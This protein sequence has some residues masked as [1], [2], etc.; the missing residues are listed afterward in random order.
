MN[1]FLAQQGWQCPICKRVY[2]PFTPCCFNCGAE[3]ITK[4]STGTGVPYPQEDNFTSISNGRITFTAEDT[5]TCDNCKNISGL[6]SHNGTDKYSGK[7]DGCYDKCNW[8]KKE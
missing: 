8:E 2:S 4:T 7:C 1:D 3:G 5:R 6:P